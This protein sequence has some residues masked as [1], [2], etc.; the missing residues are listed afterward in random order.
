[1]VGAAQPE[2]EATVWRCGIPGSL[3]AGALTSSRGAVERIVGVRGSGDLATQ[4]VEVRAFTP[5]DVSDAFEVDVAI[6]ERGSVEVTVD[7]NIARLFVV[8]VEGGTLRVGWRTPVGS[9]W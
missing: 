9:A 6:G 8:D 2:L 1:M 4:S 7:D 5:I 3:V